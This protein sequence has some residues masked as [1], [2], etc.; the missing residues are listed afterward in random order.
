MNPILITFLMIFFSFSA[1]GQ[2]GCCSWHGGVTGCDQSSGRLICADHSYSPSCGCPVSPKG[3]ANFTET[4]TNFS[5]KPA[6]I[7]ELECNYKKVYSADVLGRAN[8]YIKTNPFGDLSISA[9]MIL[10]DNNH[11]M[12]QDNLLINMTNKTIIGTQSSSLASTNQTPEIYEYTDKITVNY[13]TDGSNRNL[14]RSFNIDRVT[15]QII[16]SQFCVGPFLEPLV[17]KRELYY[18]IEGTCFAKAEA[19]LF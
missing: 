12:Y 3:K 7:I 11:T 6:T 2:R 5:E 1:Y 8:K 18:S 19:R 13:L 4:I 15:G 9:K 16:G 14:V 17:Y 10:D